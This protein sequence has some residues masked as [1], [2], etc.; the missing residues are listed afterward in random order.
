MHAEA[1]GR[2][3]GTLGLLRYAAASTGGVIGYTPLLTLLLPIKLQAFAPNDRY[4]LLVWCSVAGALTAGFANIAFGWLG[5]RSVARGGGRRGWMFAGLIATAASFVGIASARS[6]AAIVVAMVAFQVAVNALLAQVSA[7]I[8]EEVPAAQKNTAAALLTIG[9]PLAAAASALVVALASHE[10]ARLSLVAAMMAVCVAP[11]L[12]HAAPIVAT[13]TSAEAEPLPVRRALAVA[14]TTRLLVQIANS[15]VSLYLFFFLARAIGQSGD[16]AAIVAQLLVVATLVPV[17]L[18]LMLG[19]WSDRVGKRERF[20]AASALIACTGLLGMVLSGG[21]QA[22]GMCYVAFASGVSVFQALNTGHA[23]LLLP[24]GA[25]PGRN[26]GVLNL[27]NTLPQ[28][29]APLLALSVTT[30]DFTTLFALFATLP[31]AVTLLPTL[32]PMLLGAFTWRRREPSCR[33]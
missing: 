20:L 13:V 3:L 31:L 12:L 19:R 28:V 21:W 32:L 29:V 10:G 25:G 26:L 14:W 4:T 18:A 30:D 24:A 27:A 23:M 6:G 7:L 5:D 15:G 2:P 11:L 1:S 9:A 17:P 16:A 8:A 33:G 22:A